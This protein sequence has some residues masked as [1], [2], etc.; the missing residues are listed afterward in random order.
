MNIFGIN[1]KKSPAHLELLSKF[2]H[3]TDPKS[4]YKNSDWS[5]VWETVLKENPK[6]SIQR[7]VNEKYL[8]KP[9]L[10]GLL[11]FKFKLTEIKHLC[12][13]YGLIVSGKK[14]ELIERLIESHPEEISKLVIDLDILVCS[15]IGHLLVDPFI[16]SKQ[17]ERHQAESK[18]IEA[19][20]ARN[21]R[22]ATVTVVEYEKKQVFP[23]G[24]GIDWNN[25]NL[26]RYVVPLKEMYSS[27]PKILADVPE[28]KMEQIRLSAATSYLWGTGRP[29]VQEDIEGI[30]S[31]FDNP[32]AAQMVLM[33]LYSKNSLNNYRCNSDVVKF[34]KILPSPFACEECKKLSEIE[35]KLSEA[36]ELPYHRCTSKNGCRCV[37]IPVTLLSH[38]SKG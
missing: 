35:F 29:K 21:F 28:E 4:I 27:K 22:L 17:E 19:L 12:K 20:Q 18:V 1:W 8:V 23:R 5:S 14:D 6:K 34:I 33:W 31:K 16:K 25:I 30:S 2:N 26:D 13:K 38:V 9:D 15:D 3:P 11:E 37:Y 36:V 24:L 10:P 7:F 32:T